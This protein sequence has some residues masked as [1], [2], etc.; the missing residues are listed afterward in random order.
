[1]NSKKVNFK[2]VE[3][4]RQIHSSLNLLTI[5]LIIN[6]MIMQLNY[7]FTK[8]EKVNIWRNSSKFK[9]KKLEEIVLWHSPFIFFEELCL[10]TLFSLI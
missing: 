6:L 7:K 9:G 1:M 10:Y 3:L 5:R 8:L 4:N 2:I